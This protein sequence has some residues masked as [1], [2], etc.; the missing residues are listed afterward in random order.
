MDTQL[1]VWSS[2]RSVGRLGRLLAR[3]TVGH[4]AE[5]VQVTQAVSSFTTGADNDG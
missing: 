1:A 2:A 5:H 4:L 3:A